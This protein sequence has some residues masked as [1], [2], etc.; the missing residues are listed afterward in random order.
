MQ[1]INCVETGRTEYCAK[2]FDKQLN[3]CLNCKHPC[4]NQPGYLANLYQD[5]GNYRKA[6]SYYEK[7]LETMPSVL[8]NEHIDIA[9]VY[10]N[11]GTLYEDCDEK[12]KS[13]KYFRK[14]LEIQKKH[15]SPSNP[16]L[17]LTYLHVPNNYKIT[18]VIHEKVAHD[19]KY[20]K[21]DPRCALILS[22]FGN[23]LAGGQID[24]IGWYYFEK[25]FAVSNRTLGDEN[26]VTAK[27]LDDYNQASFYSDAYDGNEG[28]DA[29]EMWEKVVGRNHP[30]TANA[31]INN[32]C[33]QPGEEEKSIL[34]ALQIME[35]CFGKD[36]P[37]CVNALYA[38]GEIYSFEVKTYHKALEY[39]NKA[40]ALMPDNYECRKWIKLKTYKAI[41]RVYHNLAEQN[42]S[43][44]KELATEAKKKAVQA[45]YEYNKKFED[46]EKNEFEYFADVISEYSDIDTCYSLQLKDDEKDEY[47][48][49]ERKKR[50]ELAAEF[51]KEWENLK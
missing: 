22:D 10:Y 36:S 1:M 45:D 27:I 3:T 23:F 31:I 17:L 42:E 9:M 6:L 46:I 13:K 48:L 41:A 47:D 7:A 20:D 21:N 44:Y 40:L 37:C 8:G 15:L 34:R 25:A 51:E 35:N 4:H 30:L 38:L 43:Y 2:N 49:A 18:R 12:E 14:A 26:T 24:Q 39:F 29:I 28:Y 11:L 32:Y 5:I 33:W 50:E 16:D 19:F